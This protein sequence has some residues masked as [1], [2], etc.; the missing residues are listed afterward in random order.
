MYMC[1]LSLQY[2]ITEHGRVF[3]ADK[4]AA[5]VS[6][7]GPIACTIAVTAALEQYKG[8]IFNDTTNARVSV[9]PCT[10]R[11]TDSYMYI[12]IW[13]PLDLHVHVGTCSRGVQFMVIG[14]LILIVGCVL[15]FVFSANCI[16]YMYMYVLLRS[17]GHCL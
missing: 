4:M 11:M 8:G 2:Y 6:A 12:V 16:N 10:V 15:H 1:L 3:G 9:W 5:E 14:N 17:C 13:T 7:R